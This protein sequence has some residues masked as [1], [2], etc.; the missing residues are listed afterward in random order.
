MTS[1]VNISKICNLDFDCFLTRDGYK[2]VSNY[3]IYDAILVSGKPGLARFR[4][5]LG[6]D[7]PTRDPKQ[8]WIAQGKESTKSGLDFNLQSPFANL[9]NWTIELSPKATFPDAYF[10]IQERKK[11][12]EMSKIIERYRELKKDKSFCWI[13][14][15]CH[16][17]ND[18]F[19]WGTVIINNLFQP[20][21]MWGSAV[22][23]CMSKVNRSKVIDHGRLQKKLPNAV[24]TITKCKFYF[25]FENSNCTDYI[26][27]KFSNALE[28]YAIPIVNGWRDSYQKKLPG[29]FI[30]ISD[31]KD[32]AQLASYLKFLLQNETAYFEY[33]QWRRRFEVLGRFKDSINDFRIRCQVCK[34]V[35]ESKEISFR[36]TNSKSIANLATEFSKHQT[37]I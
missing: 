34:K 4:K 27:E 15:Q 22:N 14:S 16:A 35:L 24:E 33:F 6:T 5:Q 7:R 18:R 19:Q 8:I 23:N 32:P 3:L 37:C 21:N 20:V 1:K 2:N 9:F 13:V 28:S 26:T 17:Y 11:E 25:A 36:Q 10:Y 12:L 31:Y 30:H 29:S